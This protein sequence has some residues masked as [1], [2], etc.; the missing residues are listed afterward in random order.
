MPINNRNSGR[1]EALPDNGEEGRESAAPEI[2][3]TSDRRRR[4]G[5]EAEAGRD[6]PQQSAKAYAVSLL[7]RQDYSAATLRSRLERRGYAADEIEDAMAFVI[8]NN[9]QND[10][11]FAELRSRGIAK[12]AGNMRIEMTLRQ[13]GID[14]DMAK[15]QVRQLEPEEERVIHAAAKFKTQLQKTGMT[16]ELKMK[17]YR[18][19]AY[20]GF[21][22]KAI[23]V[24][25]ESLGQ[26]ANWV[27]DA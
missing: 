4:K 2:T 26:D 6:K 20:R 9:Y 12:R 22:A 19:L 27:E 5:S 7:A 1:P 8:G 23:R 13:K 24:A 11:R 15:E 10:E 25:I 14:A 16:P 17:I 18:F 3:R 21:S